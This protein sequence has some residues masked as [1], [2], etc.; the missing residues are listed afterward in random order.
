MSYGSLQKRSYSHSRK[1]KVRTYFHLLHCHPSCIVRYAL[2]L[3]VGE[4]RM[5]IGR[6]VYRA[7]VSGGKCRVVSGKRIYV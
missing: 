2:M 4:Y 6:D 7:Y 3:G 1:G 5:V